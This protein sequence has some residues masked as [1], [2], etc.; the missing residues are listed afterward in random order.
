[1]DIDVYD[2]TPNPGKSDETDPDLMV[3]FPPSNYYTISHTETDH[4]ISTYT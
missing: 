1:M 4:F 2:M 3:T